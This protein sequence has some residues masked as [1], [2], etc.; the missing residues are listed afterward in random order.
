M[1]LPEVGG[2]R[3]GLLN[4]S[5]AVGEGGC[6]EAGT[7]KDSLGC[8]VGAG[9]TEVPMEPVGTTP[10]PDGRIPE[11]SEG[12]T[13]GAGN[14]VSE[15]IGRGSDDGTMDGKSPEET[16]PVGTTPA[17]GRMPKGMVSEGSTPEGTADGG[18]S[19]TMDDRRLG[20]SGTTDDPMGDRMPE[21][22][23]EGVGTGAVGPRRPLEGR[24]PG[25]SESRDGSTGGKFKR[26]ELAGPVSEVGIASEITAGAVG[27]G[28]SP[29][30]KAVVM[31][32][33]I[34]E[35]GNE[36]MG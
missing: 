4:T 17:E 34:P 25:I 3:V 33:T 20:K 21:G 28:T 8:G 31:P 29:V 7:E 10:L 30:P 12:T 26:P 11:V 19:E 32:M 27:V 16:A 15:G 13:L 2:V 36:R 24:T 35:A 14:G 9:D 1:A 23:A 6:S 22:S 18:T 5:E